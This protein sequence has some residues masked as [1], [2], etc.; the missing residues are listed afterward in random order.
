MDAADMTSAERAAEA[1]SKI[2]WEN[3]Q[4]KEARLPKDVTRVVRRLMDAFDAVTVPV[5]DRELVLETFNKLARGHA[6]V[7]R[8]DPSERWSP[9]S[10][11]SVHTRDTVRVKHDAY[12]DKTGMM[13]N[14]RRGRVIAV[15][16]GDIVVRYEDGRQPPFEAVHHPPVKLE[17]LLR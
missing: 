11:G 10:P 6:L 13:H 9:A 7:V 2:E 1:W 12:M 5:K 3:A 15:R 17:R 14:G 16:Y 8:D 4:M